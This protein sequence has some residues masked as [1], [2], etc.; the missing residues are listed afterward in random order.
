MVKKKKK[1]RISDRSGKFIDKKAISN[2]LLSIF[3]NNP[4]KAYNYRQI[5]KQLNIKDESVK[6]LIIGVLDEFKQ[7]GTLDEAY[8]GKYK[9]KPKG[10]FITGTVHLKAG[11]YALLLTD[12]IKE[13]VLIPHNYLNRALD[14]DKVK[15]HLYAKRK[16]SFYEGEVMEVIDRAK[17]SI[18]GT[19]EVSEHYAFLIPSSRHVP[20]DIFIPKGKL[21]NAKDGQK[22][23][24]SIT[25]WPQRAKNPF[26]EI[27]DVLGNAGEND[28][29]MH[30]ILAEFDLPHQFPDK[31]NKAANNIAE[32]IQAQEIKKRRDIRN[33]TT[34]TIDPE[35]AKDFDDA[36]SVKKLN[37]GNWEIGIHIADVTHYVLPGN[38]ID[39]EAYSR[40]TSVY[41]VD[42]VVPMLPESL[43]NNLCSLR[44]N[45]DKLC[46]S[47]IFELDSNATIKEKWFGRTVIH[48]NRRFNYEEV[49]KVIETGKGDYNDEICLLNDLVKKL[50]DQRFKNGSVAFDRVEVKFHIDQ[51]GVPLNLFFK[52][53]KDA[54]K[55][56]E[57]FMLLAN[58]EVAGLF[59]P[60]KNKKTDKAAL[61]EK[62]FV[63][64]V[65]D[66]PDNEKLGVIGN[67]IKNLGYKVQIQKTGL[68]P[69][70]LNQLL[71]KV[72][73]T[74]EQDIVE[75]L[76]LR[77]MAKAEYS[78]KNI[79]HYG[80]AFR[81]YTHFTSPIRRYPDMMV[82]RLL[83][84]HLTGK[85]ADAKE[86][87][88]E[89]CRH[90]SEMERRAMSAE[91]ASI[92]YKQVEFIRDKIGEH[93]LGVISGVTN[94]GIFVE[95]IENKCEGM[96]PV[97]TMS[98]DFF[99]L[100]EEN[101]SLTG[102]HT[103]K[104]YQLG[105]QVMVKIVNASLEKRQIDFKLI[106]KEIPDSSS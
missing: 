20:Y 64:R 43:S 69:T 99:V 75:N 53:Q 90:S 61:K 30:A 33:T 1:K 79:G 6:Q 68:S 102:R 92:K 59:Y 12:D 48:S 16:K 37:T 21:N 14:G 50:R 9:F 94:K 76:V 46:F 65:H 81:H 67:F 28:T 82:H 86:D 45:E 38:I 3:T 83:E 85:A 13:E 7:N 18:V 58:K 91:R 25:E 42:R 31:V 11:G 8:K 44:P 49:Q 66:K 84:K 47:A 96:I 106:E 2:K 74:S 97:R 35:D 105:D 87:I 54:H 77:A 36:L 10:G 52:E 51:Q 89:Q 15:V 5:A 26:G 23:I 56:V 103:G 4:H 40:A 22:A 29:E 72:K 63:Y 34:F 71:N 19:I 57:E 80:L 17:K 60:W 41:L 62:T 39:D 55:L 88:E 78:T 32:K 27:I 24:A 100:D 93:F 104:I 95:L 73:G 98:N 101:F 70:A